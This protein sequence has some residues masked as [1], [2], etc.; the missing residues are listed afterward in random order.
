MAARSL[1]VNQTAI[2]GVPVVW[3]NASGPLRATLMFRV[4][5]VDERLS[6]SGITH[7]VE[8]LALFHLGPRQTYEFNGAVTSNRTMFYAS[9][10]P[11]DMVAFIAHVTAS[12]SS[13]PYDRLDTEKSVLLA[14]A[15]S[16]QMS[17]ADLMFSL[18]FGARGNGLHRYKEF[19]LYHLTQP[20]VAAWAARGFSRDNAVLW[21]SGPPPPSLHL[22]LPAG[23][24]MA[25]APAAPMRLGLPAYV[26]APVG[27]AGASMVAPRSTPLAM[28]ASIASERLLKRLRYDKGIAYSVGGGYFPMDSQNAH[29]SLWTDA[30]PGQAAAVLNDTVHSVYAMSTEGPTAEELAEQADNFARTLDRD[31]AILA[32]LDRTAVRILNGEPAQHPGELR[33]EMQAVTPT[34]ARDAMAEAVRTAIYVGPEDVPAPAGIPAYVAPTSLPV[35]GQPHPHVKS[36]LWKHPPV[37]SVSGD[38]VTLEINPN[39][40]ITV[41]YGACAAML[42]YRDGGM[43]LVGADGTY[44]PLNPAEWVGGPMAVQQ[45]VQRLPATL[46]VPMPGESTATAISVPQPKAQSGF[47]PAGIP[48][49]RWIGLFVFVAVAVALLAFTV[50]GNRTSV[51]STPPLISLVVWAVIGYRVF[52]RLF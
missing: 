19:G 39:E 38:G 8:H 33:A 36:K 2:D 14:E 11:A 43:M 31:D 9:G 15:S 12:L 28:A 16:R 21:L 5:R 10:E 26:K 24:R 44:L 48:I 29:I 3:A 4:G 22:T 34:A 46:A 45:I 25:E 32:W 37:L 17:P 35:Q 27:G 50:F 40:R 30:Q 18:R 49:D 42:Q 23:Q 1:E 20:W 52:R 51:G 13:L 41:L 6:W 7:L 47:A